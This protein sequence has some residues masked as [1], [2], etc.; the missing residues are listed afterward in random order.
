MAAADAGTVDLRD[1]FSSWSAAPTAFEPF[2]EAKY[3]RTDSKRF[4]GSAFFQGTT[5]GFSTEKTDALWWL[6]I[7]ADSNANKLLIA[8]LDTD[9]PPHVGVLLGNTPQ[10]LRAMAGAALGGYV[11]CGINTTR[12]GEGL[13]LP[14]PLAFLASSWW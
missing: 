2:I 12:R 11:L 4:G 3:V 14:G 13:I 1:G 8:L 10:M 9:R 6:M 5:M 7:S